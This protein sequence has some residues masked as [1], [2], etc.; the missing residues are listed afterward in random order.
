MNTIEQAIQFTEQNLK[1]FIHNFNFIP[2]DKLNWS[3]SPTSKTSMQILAHCAV[4]AQG[5]VEPI[6]GKDNFTPID[7]MI[8]QISQ[9]EAELTDKEQALT[10]LKDGI[11]KGLKAMNGLK[12][13][14]LTKIVKHPFLD[15]P[16]SFWMNLYWRHLDV[17]GG[18]IDY[19][20]TVWGDNDFHFA[21]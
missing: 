10:V 12:P 18:Q 7:D 3:P 5:L 9:A 2:E 8:K 14:D 11:S 1:Q 21:R 17:H 4:A 19:L 13:E 15:A 20:Q 6:T 16:I